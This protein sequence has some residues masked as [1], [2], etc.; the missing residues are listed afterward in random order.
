[1]GSGESLTKVVY[2]LPKSAA[3]T[4]QS[5]ENLDRIFMEFQAKRQIRKIQDSLEENNSFHFTK[6]P[7]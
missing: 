3:Y 5:L 1:M 4:M 7:M 2:I 6:A